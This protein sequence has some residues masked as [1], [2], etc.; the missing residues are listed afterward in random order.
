M[1]LLSRTLALAAHGLA[2]LGLLGALN[3]TAAPGPDSSDFKPA[4]P[5]IPSGVFDAHAF[6]AVGDGVTVDTRAVQSAISAASAAG[7]GT[8]VFSKGT[9]LC[10]PVTLS[11]SIGLR[12]EE[13]AVVRML[14]LD[15]YPGGIHNPPN[16][17]S[18]DSLHDIAITGAGTIE[19]QGQPWWPFAK[20]EGTRRPIMIHLSKCERVLIE[21]VTLRNSPMFHIA[22]GGKSSD[23]T[24]RGVTIRAPS[25]T[26]PVTPSH[27]TDACD[28]SGHTVLI[29]NCDVSVGD[30]NFT[31]G[32][33]TH[34]IRIAH[35][36]YGTGHGV[37]IGSYTSGGVSDIVVTDCTFN[38]TECG[39]R[40]KSDR[41]RGGYVHHLRYEN[42]TMTNVEFP[43]LVYASYLA[44][45]REFRD[46]THLSPEAA[47]RFPSQPIGSKTPRFE[48]IVFRSISAT[49][50]PGHRAGLI[51]G[52][53]EAPV[54]DIVLENVTITA[55]LPFGVY[56]ADGVKLVNT[57]F[58]TPTGKST[59][60]DY[61]A[62][63]EVITQK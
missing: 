47:A 24:V 8:V 41:D 20:K 3:L 26:D 36:K 62:K 61:Q 40:I 18:G 11:S 29:E 30:D 13:G 2:T 49:T 10:G 59:V 60:S 23:I 44:K 42:L 54:R 48:D 21:G 27:N 37:S 55:D 17:I 39:I 31:C 43:I 15:Q 16:F 50:T 35:C 32:G 63:L 19:G 14:P 45:G 12:I 58:K 57:T 52:L 28:V 4:T 6:G 53:P 51:W 22:I 1:A 33:G 46:L 25:S 5:V 34:D 7:G 56:C 9:Y 38:G